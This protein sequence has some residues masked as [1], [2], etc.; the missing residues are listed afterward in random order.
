MSAK[1]ISAGEFKRIKRLMGI[2]QAELA[3]IER[4]KKLIV[5]TLPQEPGLW[6]NVSHAVNQNWSASELL[7]VQGVQVKG[8]K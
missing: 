1:R 3:S 6:F 4:T 8:K 2:A 5:D 7:R